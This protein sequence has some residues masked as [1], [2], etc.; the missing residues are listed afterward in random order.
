[1]LWVLREPLL[2]IT[3]NISFNGE[4]KNIYTWYLDKINIQIILF[5]FSMKTNVMGT[6]RYISNEY[7]Q[8]KF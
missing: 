1:M 6:W 7:L 2:I 4:I 3:H 8:H 5:L